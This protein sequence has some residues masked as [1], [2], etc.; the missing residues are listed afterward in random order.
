M[1]CWNLNV[2]NPNYAEI[3]T[4]GFWQV[5][6]SDALSLKFPRN[7]FKNQT[8]GIRPFG[9]EPEQF[10]AQM[11]KIQMFYVRNLNYVYNPNVL[12]HLGLMDVQFSN[13]NF[14]LKSEQIH[15]DFGQILKTEPSGTGPILDGHC[16]GLFASYIKN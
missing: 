4:F 9:P 7:L 8:F 16:T 10:W 2:Q 13:I 14:C 6:I 3:R 11:S 1:K 5:Q 15:L 12:S